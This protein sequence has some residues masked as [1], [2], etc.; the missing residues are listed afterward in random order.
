MVEVEPLV[1]M[2]AGEA[3]WGLDAWVPAGSLRRVAAAPDPGAAASRALKAAT[4]RSL[5]LVVRDAHRS[6]ATRSLVTAVLAERPDTILVEM[7]LPYWQPPAGAYQ[8]Y[9]ATYGASRANAQAAAE[10][11]GLTDLRNPVAGKWESSDRKRGKIAWNPGKYQLV[12]EYARG[13]DR[14]GRATTCRCG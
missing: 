13:S 14:P 4:G 9:L 7:G 3:R 1:N 5:I 8:A 2:A 10:L 11:L 12:W 6:P